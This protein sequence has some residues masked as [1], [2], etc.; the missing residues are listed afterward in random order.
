M[1][2]ERTE[3]DIVNAGRDIYGSKVVWKLTDDDKGKVVV[4]DVDSGD[5]EVDTVEAKARDRL[6]SRR[7]DACTWTEEFKGRPVFRGGWRM[8]YPNGY[9]IEGGR[10]SRDEIREAL[11]EARRRTND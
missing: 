7:P 1:A 5:Y 2:A 11:A 9:T 3:T 8:T 6:L 4:I 10:P